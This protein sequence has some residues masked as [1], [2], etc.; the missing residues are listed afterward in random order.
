MSPHLDSWRQ[1]LESL[2]DNPTDRFVASLV[3]LQVI[4]ERIHQCSW[5]GKIEKHE[6]NA[7]TV[8]MIDSIQAE[9]RRFYEDLPIEQA[10]N[11]KCASCVVQESF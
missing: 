8:F 4:L 1:C 6:I 2:E 5:H 11:R 3:R 10:N 7:S 9:L